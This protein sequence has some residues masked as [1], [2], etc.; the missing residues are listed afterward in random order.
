MTQHP[1]VAAGDELLSTGEWIPGPSL[2]RAMGEKIVPGRAERYARDNLQRPEDYSRDKLIE[3]G[4]RNLTRER[5]SYRLSVGVWES[6]PP[7][8]TRAHWMGFQAW[9]VRAKY[10]G[11]LN[12]HEMSERM[13]EVRP[14]LKM[15]RNKLAKWIADG[16]VPRPL[17][18][19]NGLWLVPK[20]L[21]PVF[22]RVAEAAP[23]KSGRWSVEPSSL[24]RNP[25]AERKCP[26]C[27]GGIEIVT[28]VRAVTGFV[29]GADFDGEEEPPDEPEPSG[30]IE[31]DRDI[32]VET[33][34]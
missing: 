17:K 18:P 22:M 5:I 10:P 14:D 7:E 4:R 23:T 13:N 16:W 29:V 33:P 28:E 2:Q 9:K 6:D 11:A 12:I 27:G 32:E 8:M 15:N 34:P 19:N 31:L 26:H 21:V 25:A 24:W 20:E 3:M 1:E 30:E